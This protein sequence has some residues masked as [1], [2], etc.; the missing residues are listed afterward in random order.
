[1]DMA[2]MEATEEDIVEEESR[3]LKCETSIE[4]LSP[5]C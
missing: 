1:M 5:G 3:S 4:S 2:A